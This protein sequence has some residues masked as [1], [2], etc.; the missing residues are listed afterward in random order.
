VRP[1]TTTRP[2]RRTALLCRTAAL[3]GGTFL[4]AQLLRP[5]WIRHLPVTFGALSKQRVP[6]DL[7]RSWIHPLRHNRKVRRD[8]PPHCPQAAE[9]ELHS[10]RDTLA[11]VEFTI[12]NQPRG[13]NPTVHN[14]T[15][16]PLL[17]DGN[18]LNGTEEEV[19]E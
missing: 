9:A 15:G 7:F 14:T 18:A 8:L 11:K 2:G 6:D 10:E 1:S 3:S 12:S 5:R 17:K 19:H 4:T 13:S 16:R